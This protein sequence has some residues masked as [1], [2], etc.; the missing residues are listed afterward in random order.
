MI[1]NVVLVSGVQQSDSVIHIYVSILFQILFPFRLLYNIEQS[2]LCYTVGPCWLSILDIAV[3]TCRSQTPNL[4]LPPLSPP[5]TISVSSKS[6]KSVLNLQMQQVSTETWHVLFLSDNKLVT[7]RDKIGILRGNFSHPDSP[8]SVVF[9]FFLMI[10][11]LPLSYTIL[12]SKNTLI[13]R[14]CFKIINPLYSVLKI[15]VTIKVK[16]FLYAF[17]FKFFFIEV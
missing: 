4:S 13:F 6:V 11:H 17:K 5:V 3:C 10:W 16:I 14:F 9:F 15:M 7:N 8:K 12:F 2:F 1:N